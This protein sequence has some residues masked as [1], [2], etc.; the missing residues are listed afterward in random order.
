MKKLRLLAALI[1]MPLWVCAQDI[2]VYF[3]IIPEEQLMQI[4]ANRRKDMIDLKKAGQPASFPNRLG[5][6]SEMTELT[7]DYLRIRVSDNSTFEM[8]LLSINGQD[9]ILAVVRTTCAPACDSEILFY[10]PTERKSVV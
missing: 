9:N 1:A 5:G 2:A 10:T 7:N 8:K 3:E 4:D 6:V